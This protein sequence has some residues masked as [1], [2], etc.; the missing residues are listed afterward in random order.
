VPGD[1]HS[2]STVSGNRR[3]HAEDAES[4]LPA[5]IALAVVPLIV[6][7]GITTGTV[8]GT[9]TLPSGAVIPGAQVVLTNEASGLQLVQKA[10]DDGSFKFFLIPIGTYHALIT[11]SGFPTNRS[12]AS[13]LSPAPLPL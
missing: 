12:T 11:A 2:A 8:S 13:R 1:C 4:A 5:V 3:N 6:A 10:A 9:V 7:Q